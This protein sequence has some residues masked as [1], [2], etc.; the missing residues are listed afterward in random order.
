MMV[1][2]TVKPI[3]LEITKHTVYL[4]QN[5]VLV[6]REYLGGGKTMYWQYDETAMTPEEFN[7]SAYSSLP[8]Q[9][10]TQQQINDILTGGD[11]TLADEN[12]RGSESVS[13][14]V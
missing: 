12:S 5:A 10:R 4:R 3:E 9:L 6:K 8:A 2:S 1:E 13:E 14:E 11:G 7:A